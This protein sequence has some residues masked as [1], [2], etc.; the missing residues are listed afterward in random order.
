MLRGMS[1]NQLIARSAASYTLSSRLR[2]RVLRM[3]STNALAA[4]TQEIGRTRPA[5]ELRGPDARQPS[6]GAMGAEPV[7]QRRLEAVPPPPGKPLP[8]GSLLDLRV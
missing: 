2:W 8:R 5:G 1:P 7:A 6:A 4:F 3:I